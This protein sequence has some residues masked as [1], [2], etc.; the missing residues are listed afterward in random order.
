MAIGDAAAA[1][2]MDLVSGSALANTIDTEINKTRDY[3][4]TETPDWST[5]SGKPTEFPPA[6]HSA[7]KITSGTVDDARLPTTQTINRINNSGSYTEFEDDIRVL[8]DVR[9]VGDVIAPNATPATASFVAAWWNGDGR[10]GKGTS[11]RRYK[12]AIRDAGDLGDTF[13]APL[14]EFKYNGGDGSDRV[15]YIAEELEDA[16]LGRYVVYDAEGRAESIDFVAF[17][18]AQNAQ[19]H[20]RIT[21]LE[22]ARA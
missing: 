14:R 6:S 21:G 7:A 11:S 17:L 20:A 2:G 13:A 15:G 22:E 18:M 12:H 3:I 5:L 16:G 19:L 1:A 8:E 9:V 10:L 4:A